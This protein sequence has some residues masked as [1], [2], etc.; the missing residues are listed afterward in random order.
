[1]TRTHAAGHATHATAHATHAALCCV[2]SNEK[3]KVWRNQK[4]ART[5][6]PPS[7]SIHRREAEP[8][9]KND[10]HH[11]RE[12]AAAHEV[13]H[14]TEL[15][16]VDFFI[17]VNPPVPVGLARVLELVLVLGQL[18]PELAVRVLLDQHH[19]NAP[20]ANSVPALL[21]GQRLHGV[22]CTVSTFVHRRACARTRRRTR[23]RFRALSL[24]DAPRRQSPWTARSRART[25]WPG[26]SRC[27]GST[28]EFENVQR[29]RRQ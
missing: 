23:Q 7:A 1:M 21:N 28:R 14:S 2:N 11:A 26:S 16:L 10:T 5:P 3:T 29:R 12:A 24:S 4:R 18:R 20:V 17:L 8:L 25:T 27:R 19:L 6:V 9:S 15:A 22:E 13:T